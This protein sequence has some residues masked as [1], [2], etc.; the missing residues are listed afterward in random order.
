MLAALTATEVAFLL[1]GLIQAVAMVLWLIVGWL[2]GDM[3]RA[4]RF[5]SA[6][7][8]LSVTA[9]ALLA[10]ALALQPREPAT[11]GLLRAGGNFS[12]MLALVAL[13]RGVWY[14]IGRPATHTGH[15]LLI[16]A[17]LLA[18]WLGL[19]PAAGAV[20]VAVLSGVQA[21]LVVATAR[22][23]HGYAAH[24]L[25][26]PSRWRWLLPLPLLVAA[27]AFTS[28]GLLAL[29][30]PAT[31]A[32]AMTAHS[33]LNVGS[34]FLYVLLSLSMHALLMALVVIR[35]ITHLQRLSRHD[36]LTGL[37]NRRSLEE[38]LT[39]QVQRSRRSGETF[40]VLMLDADR[41]KEI[42][43][44]HGHATGDRALKHL[45]AQLRGHM[46][47]VDRVARFGGEEFVVLLPGLGLAAAQQVA[48]RLRRL[49]AAAP[50]VDG[51]SI[52]ALS[53]SIG[54]AEW[55]GAQEEPSRLLVRA[56]TAMY[57]AKRDGRDQV[58]TSA[59]A[60]LPETPPD[61]GSRAM[62]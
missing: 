1:A 20:R 34:T 8:G 48:E 40:C 4:T 19:D 39:A 5:W 41:F 31:V 60:E 30:S 22:D 18:S 54:V 51:D 47:E 10:L 38:E 7:A 17:A 42:N 14:F 24:G 36:G 46:R 6:F 50:L 33:A 21:V 12:G 2:V 16:V 62:R 59:W 9:F 57:R 35:L 15:G 11:A 61:T 28:R 26:L 23:L 45:S 25:Q 29:W 56:D 3:Q 55:A 44:Q 53:V 32:T 37:L 52:I 43:D 13:Q 27:A 58:A 49:V